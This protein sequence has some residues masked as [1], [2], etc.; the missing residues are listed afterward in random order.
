MTARA[1]AFRALLQV[2]RADAY[3]NLALDAAL[4]SAGALPRQ[5]AALATELAYGVQR[6]ALSLDAALARHSRRRLE[7]LEHAVLVAL[8]LGA[9]QLL[10]LDRVPAHAAVDETIKVAKAQGLGRA[11]GFLNAVLR[12]LAEA[13]EIP[14]PEAP[15]DRISVETSHPRWIVERWAAR[16]GLE[17]TAALC[18]AD[19]EAPPVCVRVQRARAS[20]EEVIAQLA[21]DDVRA[22]P[23]P[24]SPLGLWLEESGPIARLGAFQR[25]LFQVQDEA[26]QLVCLMADARPGMRVLDACA[27][28]GGKACSLAEQV[29]EGGEVFALDQHPRKLQRVDEEARRLGL[30]PRLRLRSADASRPLPFPEHSFD[31]I[32]LDA[33]CTGLGTLRRHPELRYRRKPADIARLAETQRSLLLNLLPYLKSGGCLVYAVCSPEP[34]EGPGQI[35]WLR[36]AGLSIERPMAE[37]VA[38][39]LVLDGSGALT[40]WPHRHRADGFFAARMRGR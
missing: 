8:R 3:L 28:P 35:D 4:K 29:G 11:A 26:A 14:L 24:F 40:T 19:N 31:L 18:R 9:Y 1:I 21:K 34:E 36:A 7:K 12:R 22:Y 15:L 38:W 32:L 13:P 33:P 20:R 27:A 2:E 10:F 37:G 25:G 5:E 6:R 39:D 17:E 16:L 23:T 30:A